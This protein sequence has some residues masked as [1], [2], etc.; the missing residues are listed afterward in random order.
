MVAMGGLAADMLEAAPEDVVIDT[1]RGAFH[2]QGSPQPARTW[3]ELAA[4]AT[5]PL[6]AGVPGRGAL[7]AVDGV[8]VWADRAGSRGL[9]GAPVLAAGRAPD[10]ASP[11]PGGESRMRW[12]G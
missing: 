11:W 4:V 2:V 7:P 1:V 10:C 3:S 5:V 8:G 9:L 6:V 12:P